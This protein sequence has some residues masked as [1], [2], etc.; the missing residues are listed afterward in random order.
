MAININPGS[1]LR[2]VATFNATGNWVAPLGTNLAFVS[3]H[4]AT[5]GGGTLGTRYAAS[6]G[7]Y[8]GPAGGVGSVSGA[9]V[10]VTP[11]SAHS[12]TI[13]AGGLGASVS[14]GGNGRTYTSSNVGGSTIFDSAFTATSSAGGAQGSRYSNGGTSA[15]GTPAT[16]T[17]SL[18]AVNPGSSTLTRVG[19]IASQNT[20]GRTGGVGG[21]ASGDSRYGTVNAGG[22]GSTGLVH[23]Y[24]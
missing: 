23:I 13:G 3:I 22:V 9:Y 8:N 18:T 21:T 14:G 19:T 20:G 1:P 4:G 10:Q 5:G 11:G 7:R 17:T 16:G 24:I 6:E 15:V 12:V 2:H